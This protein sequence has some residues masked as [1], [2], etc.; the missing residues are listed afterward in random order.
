MELILGLVAA[1]ACH[2]FDSV[3]GRGPWVSLN[4]YYY[5]YIDHQCTVIVDGALPFFK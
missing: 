1:W 5:Y 4:F 3:P 2:T